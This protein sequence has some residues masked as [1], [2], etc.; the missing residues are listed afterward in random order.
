MAF[1]IIL[2]SSF[3][4][5]F[6]AF[7]FFFIRFGNRKSNIWLALFFIGAGGALLRGYLLLSGYYI[8]F[9]LTTELIDNIRYLLAPALYF[10]IRTAADDR[11]QLRKYDILHLVPLAL[12]LVLKFQSYLMD[13]TLQA[14]NLTQWLNGSI[15]QPEFL[16]DRVSR[17]VFFV[18]FCFLLFLSARYYLKTRKQIEQSSAF[19]KIYS[20]WIAMFIMTLIP[21]T[22]LWILCAV[23]LA[24]GR[25]FLATFYA[26]YVFSACMVFLCIFRLLSRPEI[27]YLAKP[28]LSSK[29]Y[30]SSTLTRREVEIYHDK[31]L[32]FM[33]KQEAY[34]DPDLT[35]AGLAEELGLSR[36]DLSRIINEKLGRSFYDFINAYR[37]EKVKQ[38]LTDPVLENETVL[39][40]AFQ[41]GFNSKATFNS[42]FKKFTGESPVAYRKKI[43]K[44]RKDQKDFKTQEAQARETCRGGREREFQ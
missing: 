23:L 13:S 43:N 8:H 3:L 41:A 16:G 2:F 34:L 12:I 6:G 29:K 24:L 21:I 1:L 14:H 32:T 18:Y 31:L 9:P 7:L 37:I 15:A 42:A 20:T 38:L 36:N 28:L 5:F 22:L 11:F 27:L 25:F 33:E 17:V 4:G 35:L 26:M 39:T 30:H 40:L 10:H 19:G 44:T